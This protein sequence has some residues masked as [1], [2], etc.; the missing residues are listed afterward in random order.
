[1]LE[2]TV[3][4]AQ[5]LGL[6]GGSQG[7]LG[8]ST[9]IAHCFGEFRQLC[10]VPALC[11]PLPDEIE[12]AFSSLEYLPSTIQVFNR[13]SCQRQVEEV[14]RIVV[15]VLAHG[16]V[17]R[18]QVPS[19]R[20]ARG[21]CSGMVVGDD[22]R[23]F[24]RSA[25]GHGDFLQPARRKS[26]IGVPAASKERFIGD[27]AKQRVAEGELSRTTE[28]G[29]IPPLHHGPLRQF[30]EVAIDVPGRIGQI[31]QRPVPER[32][33]D[34]CGTV[35]HV[36]LGSRNRV[37]PGLEH[38][39]EGGGDAQ[40]AKSILIDPEA[41]GLKEDHSIVYEHVG[42]FFQ[43][44]RISLGCRCHDRSD[45]GDEL[46]VL[47]ECLEKIHCVIRAQWAELD[48]SHRS[49]TNP[50][51]SAFGQDR[52]SRNH[53][54]DRLFQETDQMI[55]H[56]EGCLIRPV[57]VLDQ[58]H[59]RAIVGD[60]TQQGHQVRQTSLVN[61]PGI[62]PA[63]IHFESQQS[64]QT[65]RSKGHRCPAKSLEQRG[66]DDVN[67]V[68]VTQTEPIG[69]QEAEQTVWSGRGLRSGSPGEARNPGL[70]EV[71]IELDQ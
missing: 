57:Q 46:G 4:V 50:C 38:A 47:E 56:V 48:P 23:P 26:V 30:F 53:H 65:R 58:N 21:A 39:C 5:L 59:N 1:M 7:C 24:V 67:R 28:L 71:V 54:Q 2:G 6:V 66:L 41:P 34:H 42:Q 49:A 60:R 10:Q 45:L 14:Q 15:G 61:L 16:P 25:Y 18:T 17:S 43:V 35:E 70:R 37:E 36:A 13:D 19:S 40:P 55:Y 44:I 64:P 69:Y 63:D 11:L 62:E 12:D 20:L 31:L 68:G 33:P 8:S 9:I 51:G 27:V 3:I 29:A 32:S 22:T 52:T